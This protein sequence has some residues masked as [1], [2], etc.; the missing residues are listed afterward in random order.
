L[1]VAHI[2]IFNILLFVDTHRKLQLFHVGIWV[3]SNAVSDSSD[4]EQRGRGK[5][6]TALMHIFRALWLR[7]RL[8][9][10]IRTNKLGFLGLY[11]VGVTFNELKSC[12]T[13]INKKLSFHTLEEILQTGDLRR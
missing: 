13:C 7:R 1:G 9:I 12:A 5:F 6:N 4:F 11:I 10:R 8:I 3:H 2:Y